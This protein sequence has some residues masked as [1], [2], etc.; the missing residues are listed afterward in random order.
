MQD[1]SFFGFPQECNLPFPCDQIPKLPIG[2][3][4]I[5]LRMKQKKPVVITGSNLVQSAQGWTLDYLNSHIGNSAFHVYKSRNNIFKYFDA[6]RATTHNGFIPPTKHLSMSFQ[7]FL[8]LLKDCH[9]HQ[10]NEKVYF[11]HRLTDSIGQQIKSDY[12]KFNWDWL[13]HIQQILEWGKLTGNLLL[14][15]MQGNVTP[16]HFDEQENMFAQIRGKKRIFLFPPEQ[17]ECFYAYPVVHPC[18]RQGQV[19]LYSPDYVRFPKFRKASAVTTVLSPS[20]VLYIPMYWWHHL[21]ILKCN[22]ESL[23]E[24]Y[25]PVNVSINFW[26]HTNPSPKTVTYPVSGHHRVSIMRNVEKMLS[27]A[28]TDTKMVGDLLK[29]LSEGRFDYDDCIENDEENEVQR[30]QQQFV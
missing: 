2:H 5:L 12:L 7:H 17:F 25:P 28:L 11:Q 19:N 3:P 9:Q 22:D 15:G 1:K 30:R 10:E 4:E 27:H 29:V 20:E 24:S 26:Y 13:K 23:S 21:E 16:I 8:D 18:D 14:I 6:K